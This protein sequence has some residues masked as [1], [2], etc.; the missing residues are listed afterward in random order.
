VA[1]DG[2]PFQTNGE[3]DEI[4]PTQPKSNNCHSVFEVVSEKVVPH[5]K[6]TK[7]LPPET[8]SVTEALKM[9]QDCI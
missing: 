4:A 2:V 1:G 9:P 7:G 8:E 3:I 6:P 5:A